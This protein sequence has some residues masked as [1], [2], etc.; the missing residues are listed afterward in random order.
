VSVWTV[1]HEC[2]WNTTLWTARREKRGHGTVA[3]VLC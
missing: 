2:M 1:A 3:L